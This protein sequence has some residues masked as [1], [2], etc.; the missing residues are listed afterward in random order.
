MQRYSIKWQSRN[1]EEISYWGKGYA[2]NDTQ[3]ES[4]ISIE[5]TIIDSMK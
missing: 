2:R 4:N 3:L 5:E 1:I